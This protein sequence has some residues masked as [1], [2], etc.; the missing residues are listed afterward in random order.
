MGTQESDT[1]HIIL[2]DVNKV[3]LSVVNKVITHT[4]HVDNIYTV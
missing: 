1:G 3:T 4:M 2:E